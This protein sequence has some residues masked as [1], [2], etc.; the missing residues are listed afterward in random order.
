MKLQQCTKSEL[1]EIV[2][3]L[4]RRLLRL[5]DAYLTD[6]LADVERD[7]ELRRLDAAQKHADA[8]RAAMQRYIEIMKLYNGKKLG[9]IPFDALNEARECLHDAEQHDREWANLLK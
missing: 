2:D 9:D 5:G 1:I 3:K 8:S 7:R 4:K 6:A